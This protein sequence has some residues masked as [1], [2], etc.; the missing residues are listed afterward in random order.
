MR[1]PIDRGTTD[2]PAAE[3]AP[4]SVTSGFSPWCS[5]RKTLQMT[6]DSGRPSSPATS[7][8]IDVF[9]CS[10]ESTRDRTTSSAGVPGAL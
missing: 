4:V 3:I 2:E 5:E 7:K 6:G 1:W 10:P 8:M 9:D